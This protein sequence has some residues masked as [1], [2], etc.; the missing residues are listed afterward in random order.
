MSKSTKKHVFDPNLVAKVPP[1][2]GYPPPLDDPLK[3]R[4]MRRLAGMANLEK[5]AVVLIDL[6][7]GAWLAQRLWQTHEDEF[8]YVLE[9]IA[10]L[11]TD[12][13]EEDMPAGSCVGFAAGVANAHHII[14]KSDQTVRFLEMANTADGINLT[15]YPHVDLKAVWQDGERIFVRSNGSLITE[16][17]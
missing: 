15:H 11:V 13:G 7:P 3:G 4:S 10:T 16:Q 12:D 5:L 6:E 1:G 2:R 17:A 14:N 8:V 9:G